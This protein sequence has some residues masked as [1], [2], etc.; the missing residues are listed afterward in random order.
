MLAIWTYLAIID[1][2]PGELYGDGLLYFFARNLIYIIAIIP[3][4]L[5]LCFDIL[6][7]PIEIIIAIIYLIKRRRWI[8]EKNIESIIKDDYC[9][10]FSNI[11][12]FSICLFTI[13]FFRNHYICSN[14][15][16]ILWV[17]WKEW[18]DD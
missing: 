12:N 14:F 13:C 18:V 10:S 7:S 17:L 11:I 3:S 15:S 8:D 1:D 6:I 4:L 9:T 5:I 16:N 2:I